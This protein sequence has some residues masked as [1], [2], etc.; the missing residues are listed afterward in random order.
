[1]NED[2]G[3]DGPTAEWAVLGKYPGRSMGYAVLD[4]SLPG[5]RAQ[6]YLWSATT[7]TPDARD[8]AGGLPWRVFLSGADG[9]EGS[10]CA[11]VDTS[12]DG[13]KDGTGRPSYSWRL[14][15]FEWQAASRAG[16][17]WTELDRAV[18]RAGSAPD[19]LDTPPAATCT[20]AAELA[21]TADRLG[22]EW[23]AAMAALLLDGQ[24]LVITVPPGGTVPGLDERVRTLD[25]V[26]SLLPYGC[27]AWLSGATW[28]GKAEHELRL[29]FAASARTGQQ[30]APLGTG[31]PPAPRSETAVRYLT[32]LLRLREKL[33]STADVV[34]HLLAAT[35]ALPVRDA[36]QAVRV[37]KELDLLDSALTDIRQGRGRVGDV[38]RLLELHAVESLD[39]RQLQD[40]VVFLAECARRPDGRA[41]QALLTRPLTPRVPELLAAHVVAR[42]ASK[43][44]LTLAK[45]YL[46]LLLGL[47]GAHPDWFGR[48]FTALA[49]TPGYDPAW[50]GNLA[51][52]VEKEFGYHCEAVDGVLVDSRDAGLAWLSVLLRARAR[53]LRPLSRLVALAARAGVDHRPGWLRFAGLLT[54]EFGATEVVATDAAEFAAGHPDAWL[55]ALETARDHGRSAAIGPMWAVLRQLVRDGRHHEVLTALEAVAPPGAPEVRPGTAADADLLRLSVPVAGTGPRLTA[56]M[57]RLRRLGADDPGLDAYTA[58]VVRRTEA[59]PELTNQVVEALLGEEPD[60][61][62][63][64]WT[65]LSRWMRQ[66]PST[67]LTVRAALARRLRSAAHAGWLDLD[68][69]DDLVDGLVHRDGLLWLRPVRQLRAASAEAAP[70]SK[71]GRI[72][73]EACP[74]GIFS[75]QLLDEIAGLVRHHGTPFAFDLTNELDRQRP[76]LGLTLY[77]AIGSGRQYRDVR[78]ELVKGSRAV[79]E[80]HRVILAALGAAGT[81][82]SAETAAT[83]AAPSLSPSPARPAHTGAEGYRPA[84]PTSADYPPET[85]RRLGFLPRRRKRRDS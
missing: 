47:E 77:Q 29:V 11:V 3:P 72:V 41:A 39:E 66:R 83:P 59:A 23:A 38:Q 51:Y 31:R 12:W 25:A 80:R 4:G 44:T 61:D 40:V 75:H 18:S 67:D 34:A 42:A 27:R 48:L 55:I 5:T 45:E 49:A 81:L 37:L 9:E 7:G 28:T 16:V 43:Q 58:T 32:E 64:S 15:L 19:R 21:D 46:T 33:G 74:Y 79:E 26:C 70:L 62:S 76:G 50:V 36:A 84:L 35:S 1:M 24:R 60:P 68:L 22:F 57:P 85:H 30:E 2:R 78:D 8:P 82:P 71:L 54:G 69:P 6:R 52:M 53:D 20:R 56:T 63:A 65:V 73:A 17:T 14:L 13:S 10:V